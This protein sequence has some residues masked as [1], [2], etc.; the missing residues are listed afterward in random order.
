M[1]NMVFEIPEEKI[2]MSFKLGEQEYIA[3]SEND[4]DEEIEMMFAKIDYIDGLRIMRN[5]ETVD[6]YEKVVVEFDSRL[7]LISN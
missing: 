7:K 4:E 3:F 6:E 2:Y 5:I 1:D